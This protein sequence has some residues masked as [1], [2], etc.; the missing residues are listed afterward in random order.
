MTQNL[1]AALVVTLGELPRWEYREVVGPL[2]R[3]SGL[4]CVPFDSVISVRRLNRL[5][6]KEEPL[7]WAGLGLAGG[8]TGAALQTLTI[9]LQLPRYC[10]ATAPKFPKRPLSPL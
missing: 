8:E 2:T 10:L 9:A 7:P 5:R 6:P 3:S 1:E 4:C